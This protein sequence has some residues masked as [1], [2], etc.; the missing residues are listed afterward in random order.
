MITG[1][2]VDDYVFGRTDRAGE[3]D[4][5]PG[6][7]TGD[8]GFHEIF[9]HFYFFIRTAYSVFHRSPARGPA[10]SSKRV[11]RRAGGDIPLPENPKGRVMVSK[12]FVTVV[13]LAVL[14]YSMMGRTTNHDISFRRLL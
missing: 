5:V 1:G 14:A 4:H 6:S 2:F 12:P 3:S 13:L 10:P 11:L 9:C 8:F 7:C